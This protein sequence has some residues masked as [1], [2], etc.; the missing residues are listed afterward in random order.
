MTLCT[1]RHSA[2]FQY[3]MKFIAIFLFSIRRFV[4]DFSLYCNGLKKTVIRKMNGNA[5]NIYYYCYY[6]I[7]LIR[8]IVCLVIT[9]SCLFSRISI[10]NG[11]YFRLNIYPIDVF[12]LRVLLLFFN[13]TKTV[14][15][16]VFVGFKTF[17]MLIFIPFAPIVK[18]LTKQKQLMFILKEN[19]IHEKSANLAI[20]ICFNFRLIRKPYDVW[21]KKK[22]IQ[23]WRL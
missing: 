11:K 19:M 23:I 22:C 7:V 13:Q 4:Y 9:V 5:A 17:W 16:A 3:F 1:F 20:C 21:N 15:S 6:V 18:R 8:S 2:Q 12:G 10:S 14:N